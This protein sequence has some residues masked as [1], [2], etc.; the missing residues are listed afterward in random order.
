MKSC[1]GLDIMVKFTLIFQEAQ[2][3]CTD[4]E[5]F[6]GLGYKTCG[7]QKV[8]YFATCDV[9]KTIEHHSNVQINTL[10]RG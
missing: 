2:N 1:L 7:T 9:N 8:K 3:V 10:C 5:N 6:S 4:H